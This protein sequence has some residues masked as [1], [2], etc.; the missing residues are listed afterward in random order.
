MMAFYVRKLA[1]RKSIEQIAQADRFED[2]LADAATAE[3]RT[4][5]GTLSTWEIESMEKLDEAVLAIAATSTKIERMDF[6]VISREYIEKN[7]LTCES[8][9]A[10]KEIAIPDLQDTHYDIKGV[11]FAKL[12]N[13]VRMYREI[14]DLDNDSEQYIVR[15]AEREI[16][17]LLKDALT[18]G[19]V[20]KDLL[21]KDIRD[22]LCA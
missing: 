21:P 6:I 3:F 15:Y 4:T 2:M 19:R 8:S 9:Y 20:K 13:C 7:E 16:L 5:N 18:A 22:V 11:T 10:G 14:Y 12:L 17:R 1:K